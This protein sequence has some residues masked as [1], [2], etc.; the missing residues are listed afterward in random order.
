MFEAFTANLTGANKRTAKLSIDYYEKILA[1]LPDPIF[2]RD[3][4]RHV[5]YCNKAAL[6]LTGR[7]DGGDM[8]CDKFMCNNIPE[9][10]CDS[11]CPIEKAFRSGQ[12]EIVQN[13]KIKKA[14]GNPMFG[15]LTAIVLKGEKG[16]FQGGIEI[17]RNTTDMV[18]EKQEL[19]N[20]GEM[21]QLLIR[22]IPASVI[23]ADA[24]HKVTYV[25]EGFSVFTKKSVEEMIGKTVKEVLGI[26]SDSALDIVIDTKK[27]V[28]N[29]EGKIPV[30]KGVFMPVLISAIPVRNAKGEFIGGIELIQD[31][32]ALKDKENQINATMET[33]QL[34]IRNLPASVI[35]ADAN[36]VVTY[37]SE[38]F[39]TFTKKPVQEMIGK[40]V[41]E[42]LGIK[43]D[44]VLDIVID[45]K[46]TVTNEE[47]KIPVGKGVFMPV[48]ISAIPVKNAKGEFVAGIELIQDI[49][50]IKEKENQ[51]KAQLEY[52]Q[53]QAAK[54]VSGIDAIAK[55]D[56]SAHLTKEKDDE[57]GK[58]FDAYNQ[59]IAGLKSIVVDVKGNAGETRNKA[60]EVAESASQMSTSIQQVA[61]ASGEISK[62]AE[63]LARLAEEASNRVKETNA[64]FKK[65]DQNAA[66][67]AKL[68]VEGA[69]KAKEVGTEAAN[70][71]DG[72]RLIK[73]AVSE[74]TQV[75]TGLNN[76][77]KEIGKVT[78]TI[79][80]IADQTNLLALNAAIEAARAGEHGR[81]FAV[82]AEEVRKLADESRKSTERIN[83]LIENV[84][85][86]TDQ[87][88]KSI[89]K[90]TTESTQGEQVIVRATA[91]IKDVV[92]SVDSISR[93][94]GEVSEDVRK[95]TVALETI[96]KSIESAAATAEETA[97][98]SEETSAAIE[99]Q[100]A[101]IEE[102]NASAHVL[103]D[104]SESTVRLLDEKFTLDGGA[105]QRAGK[106]NGVK[107]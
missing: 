17:I 69:K 104:V 103:N 51:I 85:H 64:L 23:I 45:T 77:V 22:N 66:A 43:S 42:V 79:K 10:Y 56:L 98:S 92:T 7:N 70:V 101:A 5:V 72:M 50:T 54:L 38:G 13:V 15:E 4:D 73:V 52:N 61:T 27:S 49:T 14:N 68:A 19:K 106:G 18:K 62:G 65:L 33:M 29:E 40:T 67:S 95:G 6:N 39:S 12:S 34:L 74:T 25:S 81:G 80:N 76:A 36:H 59:L 21:M 84:Q 16:E 28:L 75:V 46:K 11:S 2:V 78:D 32:T 63:S 105:R 1:H 37:A 24:S 89:E 41:K 100:T 107:A 102:L 97:S 91:N 48:L 83:S 86:E 20:Q 90:V 44:S 47:S 3:E 35:I 31:V 88:M 94:I 55:G 82:V 93:M 26:K 96:A 53:R 30:G 71:N 60:Q 99:E 9:G 58:T 57:F 8:K 87:V